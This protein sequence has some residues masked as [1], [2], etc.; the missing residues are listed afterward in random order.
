[1]R[2]IMMTAIEVLCSVSV[3]AE[4]MNH[5]HTQFLFQDPNNCARQAKLRFQIN[6][7]KEVYDATLVSIK[8]LFC[9]CVFSIP[10]VE[11]VC[12]QLSL[13][14]LAEVYQNRLES[15]PCFCNQVHLFDGRES[16]SRVYS[17]HNPEP[18]CA[19][20]EVEMVAGVWTDDDL[21]ISVYTALPRNWLN[22]Y[23]GPPC[24]DTADDCG[25]SLS[26]PIIAVTS[27]D[28]LSSLPV[29]VMFRRIDDSL[30]QST[31][32]RTHFM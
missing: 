3:V 32:F 2:F 11:R 17:D 10:L 27:T 14:Y 21:H 25:N 16:S 24:V 29:S 7:L 8:V 23:A 22:G 15:V 9:R 12:C 19:S 13:N 5:H 31:P 18:V 1:M 28:C 4:G 6:F 26:T 20:S 30:C